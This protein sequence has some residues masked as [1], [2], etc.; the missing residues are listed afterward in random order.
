MTRFIFIL[1]FI[2]L[3]HFV[4]AQD[5][6]PNETIEFIKEMTISNGV[7][8]EYG[9]KEFLL[10]YK[11][12]HKTTLIKLTD[13]SKASIRC[14]SFIVLIVRNEPEAKD[15]FKQHL[16]DTTTLLTYNFDLVEKKK[17]NEI[18]LNQLHPE[19]SLSDYNF[20][21]EEYEH[22]LRLIK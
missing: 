21:R 13:D 18:M 5:M 4:S 15:I 12:L 19:G 9:T 2:I 17:V 20:T 16:N 8:L 14:L 11:R 6:S 1:S 3:S 7:N 10:P 22:Y